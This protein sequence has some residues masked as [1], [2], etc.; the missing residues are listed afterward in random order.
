MCSFTKTVQMKRKLV[1][2]TYKKNFFFEFSPF[3]NLFAKSESDVE[4]GLC[5]IRKKKKKKHT[6]APRTNFLISVYVT[7]CSSHHF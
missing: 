3:G 4:K 2:F 7:C 5:T 6:I 1:Q